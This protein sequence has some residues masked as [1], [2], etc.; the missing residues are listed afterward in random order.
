VTK[1]FMTALVWYRANGE[2]IVYEV[3]IDNS[4]VCLLYRLQNVRPSALG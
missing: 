3:A 1:M 2:I 4:Y